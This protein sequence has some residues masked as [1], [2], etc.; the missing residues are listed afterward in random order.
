MGVDYVPA[1][2]IFGSVLQNSTHLSLSCLSMSYRYVGLSYY[3]RV[4]LGQKR[5]KKIKDKRNKPLPL[6]FLRVLDNRHIWKEQ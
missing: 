2:L 4:L 3:C 6:L 5:N 1:K